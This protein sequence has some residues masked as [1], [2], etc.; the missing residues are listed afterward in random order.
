[1]L[2]RRE[3][4]I[5]L[6]GNRTPAPRQSYA[7]KCFWK[8]SNAG[9]RK[10]S[11]WCALTLPIS[12]LKPQ[13]TSRYVYSRNRTAIRLICLNELFHMVCFVPQTDALCPM[14]AALPSPRKPYSDLNGTHSTAESRKLNLGRHRPAVK[15]YSCRLYENVSIQCVQ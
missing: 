9:Y 2:W 11:L 13:S 1:V 3:E 4:Y 10:V 12:D 14:V 7:C 15:L 8:D 5:A 6:N